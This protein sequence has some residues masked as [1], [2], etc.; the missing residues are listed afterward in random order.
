MLPV[1]CSVLLATCLLWLTTALLLTPTTVLGQE[2]PEAAAPAAGEETA[3][4]P[5]AITPEDLW[6]MHRIGEPALSP[7]GAWVVY[8]VTV[9]DDKGKGNSDLWLVAADGSSEPRQLTFNTGSDGS[10]TWSPDGTRLAFT[11]KRGDSP[12]QLYIL[13]MDRPGEAEPVTEL[14][15]GVGG[16][17]WFGDGSRIAFSATTWPDL[18]D[19]FE[20]VKKRRDEQKEDKVQAKSTE[21]RTLRYWDHYTTDGSVSHVFAVELEDGSVKDLTP[22]WDA[23]SGWGGGWDLSPDGKELAMSG[24]STAPPFRSLNVDIFTID[25]SAYLDGGEPAE[26]RNLTQANVA[27]DSS[28]YYTPDGRYILFGRTDRPE[29]HPDFTRLA[30]YD[31]TSGEFVELTA[32][33]DAEPSNW[34]T[35]PDGK[36]VLFQAQERARTHIFSM[37]I[38]GGEP[39][40]VARGGVASSADTANTDDGVRFVYRRQ[41]HNTPFKLHGGILGQESDYATLADP[42]AERL[43]KI[44]F[45]SLEDMDFVGAAGDSVHA[46]IIKPPGFDASKKWP[47]LHLIHGGP[48]GSFQDSFHYRWNPA[49]FASKGH[50]AVMVNFHGSTGYGQAF[51]ESILGNHA[52]LPFEDIMKATDAMIDTG[53]IDEKRMAAAGGSYGGYMVSWILGHTDRFAALINHAGVYDLMAQFASDATWGRNHNY[54]ASPWTDPD[55]I[56]LYSPSRYAKNFETPTLI[57]HGELDYRVPVTQGINQYGVLQAMGVPTRIVIFPNE[58]HWILQRDAAMLWWSEVFGWLEKYTGEG[59]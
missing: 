50:V 42:N 14:P 35:T 58:N 48:H 15:I 9:Y 41:A 45:G 44:D 10:P 6:A 26:P 33:W 29:I 17:Q 40:I 34:S 1:R 18:N 32:D 59:E 47:L 51:S 21:N 43:A 16:P 3:T 23:W 31:R 37:P 46:V 30:R 39:Q 24:N 57:L 38:D 11:S 25:L 27:G 13:P 54:G 20:A 7:D 53:Y 8:P 12:P 5:R 19:D 28:P 49:L 55:R 2:A 22:G 52:D 56:D 4:G 36:T